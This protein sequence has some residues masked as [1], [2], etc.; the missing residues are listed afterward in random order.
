MDTPRPSPRTN[1]T[2]RVPHPVLIGHAASLIHARCRPAPQRRTSTLLFFDHARARQAPLARHFR[3][4]LR[5][6]LLSATA[7]QGA[8]DELAAAGIALEPPAGGAPAGE[9]LLVLVTRAGHTRRLAARAAARLRAAASQAGW[10][11]AE[12]DAAAG[13]APRAVLHLFA[14]AAG[15][16]APHGAGLANLLT[17][18]EGTAVLSPPPPPPP[19]PSLL[20]PLP[21][22]LLY[23]HSLPP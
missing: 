10:T 3:A 5:P 23:T 8:R 2:R 7:Q 18:R 9:Q 13:L 1:R 22:S 19:P 16:A 4:A 12:Y 21:V 14:R 17:A 6:A 15:V 11:L 20:L